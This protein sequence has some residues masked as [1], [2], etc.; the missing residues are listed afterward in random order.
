MTIIET[1]VVVIIIWIL[2]GLLV[3]SYIQT[4]KVSIRIEQEKN[5][6]QE[7]LFVSEIL[8]NFADRNSLDFTKYKI[9][10]NY[11]LLANSGL[12]KTLYLSGLDWN[13]KIYSTGSKCINDWNTTN[14]FE[15]KPDCRIEVDKDWQTF[16]IT[17]KNK[18]FVNNMVFKIVPFSDLETYYQDSERKLCKTNFIAC[19]NH[20]GFWVLWEI[21]TINYS[22]GWTNNVRIPLQYFFNL[23]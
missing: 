2:S 11:E 17:N 7:L 6:T 14:L 15:N 18:T 22:S 4:S 13:I 16:P 23:Q 8:Q 21:F 1:L 20:P 5:V 3:K 19:I 9:D 10:W 12:T